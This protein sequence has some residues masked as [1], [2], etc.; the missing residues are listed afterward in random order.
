MLG[1]IQ[2]Q[3]GYIVLDISGMFSKCFAGGIEVVRVRHYLRNLTKKGKWKIHL[4]ILFPSS[5]FLFLSLLFKYELMCI[6][7]VAF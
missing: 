5:F 6:W 1:L 7:S 4:K 2:V 3:Q